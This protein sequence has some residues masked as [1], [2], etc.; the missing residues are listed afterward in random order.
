MRA[1]LVEFHNSIMSTD[2]TLVFTLNVTA[3]VNI[4]VLI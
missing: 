2:L 3:S 1:L 4:V